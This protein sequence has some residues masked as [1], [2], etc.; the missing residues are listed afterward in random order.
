MS[1][2][3]RA[4]KSNNKLCI[5]LKIQKEQYLKNRLEKKHT[6]KKNSFIKDYNKEEEIIKG[7]F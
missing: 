1:K 2:F 7:I 5:F 6:F 4:K 3:F